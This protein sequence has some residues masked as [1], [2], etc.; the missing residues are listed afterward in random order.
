MEYPERSKATAQPATT[1]GELRVFR[2]FTDERLDWIFSWVLSGVWL[3]EIV[4]AKANSGGVLHSSGIDQRFHTLLFLSALLVCVPIAF[5]I[6]RPGLAF[7]QVLIGAA[8][9]ALSLT[10]ESAFLDAGSPGWMARVWLGFLPVALLSF[11]AHPR[12][13][14]TAG[15]VFLVTDVARAAGLTMPLPPFQAVFWLGHAGWLTAAGCG[16][17][18]LGRVRNQSVRELVE[19]QIR[20]DVPIEDGLTGLPL[21]PAAVGFLANCLRPAAGQAR[22]SGRSMPEQQPIQTG[23]IT[24][25]IAVDID[26]LKHINLTL[27]TAAGD[28]VIQ[29][30]ARRFA[31]CIR[32]TDCIGRA[33]KD[34]FLIVIPNLADIVQA[35]SMTR[36]LLEATQT[37]FRHEGAAVFATASFGLAY[38]PTHGTDA[39]ALIRSAEQALQAAQQDGRA[40]FR[41]FGPTLATPRPSRAGIE[42]DLHQA[43]ARGELLLHYQ[44]QVNASGRVVCVEALLRWLHPIHGLIP[45]VEFIPI[46]EASGLILPIGE[47]VLG[48]ACR[49]GAQ[50][51]RAGLPPI[52]MA[53]NVSPVQ[54][55]RPQ[56]IK[57]VA[58]ALAAS[59][60]DACLLELEITE[61]LLM[62]DPQA[63]CDRIARLQSLGVHISIDDFGM[64]YSSLAYLQQ[65]PVNALKIDRTFVAALNSSASAL[66]LLAAIIMLA[67]SLN[68]EVVVEGVETE[69]Q[70]ET[71]WSLGAD[72]AQGYFFCRP[73]PAAEVAHMLRYP[74]QMA[75]A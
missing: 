67:H 68:L 36:R 2:Q 23:T 49:Q 6:I 29:Q 73:K 18:F 7:N 12:G 24:A 69:A 43:L 5:V 75:A 9:A 53:V 38:A 37:P 40:G 3:V 35:E 51:V 44:P 21:R 60:F 20:R 55:S 17:M 11:Y 56:F 8:W 45:P 28:A 48:E 34:E 27:G 72:K 33:G 39:Q 50:W 70:R 15:S 54:F 63:A 10:S 58:L 14:L 62:I 64:G 31:G 59:G 47:W 74:G 65:L 66:P 19:R 30:A 26:Q 22:S 4:L 13:L 16:L 32:A 46:A 57:Q 52:R 71:V 42:S 25:V 1:E 41:V 61:T